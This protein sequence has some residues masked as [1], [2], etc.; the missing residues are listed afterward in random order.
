MKEVTVFLGADAD[1]AEVQMLDVLKFEIQL[2]NISLSRHFI[3]V[4]DS[5]RIPIF[6]NQGTEA[7]SLSLVQP[8]HNQPAGQT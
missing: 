2:A 1:E 7:Q 5:K 4:I 6:C 3:K 8:Y